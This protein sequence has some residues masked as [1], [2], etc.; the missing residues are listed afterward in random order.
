MRPSTTWISIGLRMKNNSA[1]VSMDPAQF[2]E[3]L[4]Q[5][6]SKT[7]P[8]EYVKDRGLSG[9]RAS[10]VVSYVEELEGQSAL[11]EASWY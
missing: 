10:G 5:G 3:E 2:I 1:T 11:R 9:R 4:C 7:R 6:R 8:V